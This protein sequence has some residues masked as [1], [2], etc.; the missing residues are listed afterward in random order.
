MPNDR[1][2]YATVEGR[3]A[4]LARD[5]EVARQTTAAEIEI[6][7]KPLRDVHRDAVRAWETSHK[8]RFDPRRGHPNTAVRLTVNHIRHRLSNYDKLLDRIAA[9][10]GSR[11][12]KDRL[13]ERFYRKLATKYPALREEC[14]A[15]LDLRQ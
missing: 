12:E 13:R 8:V 10:G 9:A 14:Q 7:D 1:R 6:A 3:K 4:A 2:D 5:A 15:Q 11:D